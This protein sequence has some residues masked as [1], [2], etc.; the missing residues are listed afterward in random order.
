MVVGKE[1]EEGL[2]VGGRVAW[3]NKKEESSEKAAWM[4]A[5]K[6]KG[7]EEGKGRETYHEEGGSLFHLIQ[8]SALAS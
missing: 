4:V 7:G 2:A 5:S 1:R 3:K 8:A 6:A